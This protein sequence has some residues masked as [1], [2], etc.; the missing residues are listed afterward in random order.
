MKS[1][2]AVVTSDR[3]LVL[4]NA[5]NLTANVF[6]RII[7]SIES[8]HSITLYIVDLGRV[9]IIYVYSFIIYVYSLARCVCWLYLFPAGCGCVCGGVL[10]LY[11]IAEGALPLNLI[12][13]E[14]Y[15]F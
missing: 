9:T 5:H 14:R 15:F 11:C 4:M 1:Y 13:Q 2:G 7:N 3:L 6:F 8:G 12:G 10:L